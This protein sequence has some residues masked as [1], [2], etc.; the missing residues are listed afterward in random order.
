M[1]LLT[2]YLELILL[3]PCL[4]TDNVNLL[5]GHI[6]KIIVFQLNPFGPIVKMA[7][8]FARYVILLRKG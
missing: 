6:P 1:L 5:I 7:F 2:F 8:F 3:H 4:I